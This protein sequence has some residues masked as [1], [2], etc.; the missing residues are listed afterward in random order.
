MSSDVPKIV[1]AQKLFADKSIPLDDIRQSVSVSRSTLYR[2]VR[3]AKKM[4]DVF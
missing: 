1:L 3:I 2:Y 4:T